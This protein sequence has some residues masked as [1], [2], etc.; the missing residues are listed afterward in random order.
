[1]L[2]ACYDK[3]VAADPK[4]TEVTLVVQFTFVDSGSVSEAA[5]EQAVEPKFDD[6]ILGT[7]KAMKFPSGKYGKVAVNYPLKFRA[8]DP[9]KK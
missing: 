4:R 7:F 6:C 3:L 5:L 9:P 2:R 8:D 1:V